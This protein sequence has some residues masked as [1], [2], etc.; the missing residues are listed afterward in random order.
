MGVSTWSMLCAAVR[1]ARTFAHD[2]LT[3][4]ELEAICLI[5]RSAKEIFTDRLPRQGDGLQ[6]VL[7]PGWSAATERLGYVDWRRR[8]CV[9]DLIQSVSMVQSVQPIHS[10]EPFAILHKLVRAWCDRHRLEAL[11]QVLPAYLQS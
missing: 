8:G 11:N 4:G 9:V 3:E 6:N 1:N 5:V 10:E 7:T 2:E